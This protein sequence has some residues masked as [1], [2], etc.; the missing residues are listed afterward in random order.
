MNR[1]TKP[2]HSDNPDKPLEVGSAVIVRRYNGR[3]RK[4][5]RAEGVVQAL[6]RNRGINLAM[7][8]LDEPDPSSGARSRREYELPLEL[9]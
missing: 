8:L 3:A 4:F 9:A 1:K 6:Y 7:V 2:N 5:E